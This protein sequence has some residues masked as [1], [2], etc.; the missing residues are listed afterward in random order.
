MAFDRMGTA[1]IV[2][3]FLWLKRR[4]EEN[5]QDGL[6]VV[7]DDGSLRGDLQDA[8]GP[9]LVDLL[10]EERGLSLGRGLTMGL[11]Q[12]SAGLPSE[13]AGPVLLMFPDKS[14]L[15]WLDRLTHVSMAMFVPRCHEE[16]A[17]WTER[18]AAREPEPE[19][20]SRHFG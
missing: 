6:L 1:A 17:Y 3:G 7:P 15:E 12:A 10:I 9:L 14:A 19:D 13:W 2:R 8:L 11:V 16:A 4:I 5:G 18:W 20:Y